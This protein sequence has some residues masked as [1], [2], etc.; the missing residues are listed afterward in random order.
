ML[1]RFF[2]ARQLAFSKKADEPVAIK[3]INKTSS[4]I[5]Y[6]HLNGKLVGQY[7]SITKC[8]QFLGLSRAMVKKAIDSQ[9]VLDNGFIL[10]LNN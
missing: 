1:S 2:R 4:K 7:D 6:A 9:T 8:A 5:V 10:T 3:E